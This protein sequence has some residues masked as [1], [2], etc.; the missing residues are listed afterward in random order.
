[1]SNQTPE[2]TPELF[3]HTVTAYQR[4][5]ALKGAIELDIFTA[6][7]EGNQTV[8]SLAQRCS[9]SERGLINSWH[10]TNIYSQSFT[11]TPWPYHTRP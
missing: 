2:V 1:M 11:F 7:S 9:A 3:F 6:I 5:G 8:S 10:F 4:T